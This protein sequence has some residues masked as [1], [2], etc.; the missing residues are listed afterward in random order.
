[1][2][3]LHDG[4]ERGRLHLELPGQRLDLGGLLGQ[5]FMQRRIQEA[6][7]DRVALHRPEDGLEVAALHGEKLG[8]R[9]LSP[10]DVLGDD[11]LPHGEEPVAGKEHVLGAA[12][13]DALGA[14]VAPT[15]G[16]GRR[17]GVHPN[18]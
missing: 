18:A 7:G 15:V 12:Q 9:T 6:D 2:Q 17:V 10:R 11:H 13:A 1:V 16:V 4:L 5:E 14:E 8:Q 3:P